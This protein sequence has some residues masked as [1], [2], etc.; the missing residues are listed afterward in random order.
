M[1]DELKKKRNINFMLVFFTFIKSFRTLCPPLI[2]A[3]KFCV[4]VH[5][6]V[7]FSRV[8]LTHRTFVYNVD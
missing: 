5:I 3:F 2:T 1:T 8:S 4:L 7:A 6:C